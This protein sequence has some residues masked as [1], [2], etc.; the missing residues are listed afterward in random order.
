MERI[1]DLLVEVPADVVPLGKGAPSG[2]QSRG[3]SLGTAVG[4]FSDGGERQREQ[5]ALPLREDKIHG[6]YVQGARSVTV[7]RADEALEIL[8][9]AASRLAF[10]QTTMNALS[11]RA[12]A[13]TTITIEKRTVAR[14]SALPPS[15]PVPFPSSPLGHANLAAVA[16]SPSLPT[17]LHASGGS[18]SACLRPRGGG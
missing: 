16:S 5:E 9:L 4:G 15:S 11:S 7:G 17:W 13:I 1:Y 2:L 3:S 12:H 10:A 8:A 6:I 14:S 18:S